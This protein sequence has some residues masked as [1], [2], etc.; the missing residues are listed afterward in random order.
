M[1][2]N[3]PVWIHTIYSVIVM[4]YT[5][6]NMLYIRESYMYCVAL[7]AGRDIPASFWW[8]RTSECSHLQGRQG[9]LSQPL[10]AYERQ[11]IY[12]AGVDRMQRT[13]SMAA[14]ESA[15]FL[16]WP[17]LYLCPW[18]RLQSGGE[19]R[20]DRVQVGRTNTLIAT[21]LVPHIPLSLRWVDGLR[22]DKVLLMVMF[23]RGMFGT[24]K[25][26]GILKNAF[27]L[28]KK[29][30]ANTNILYWGQ[31]LV[32]L[33]EGG[34][35]H[36]MDPISLETIG[37]STLGGVLGR[38]ETLTAHPRYDPVKARQIFFSADVGPITT[39]V[40]LTLDWQTIAGAPF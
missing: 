29:N 9:D 19:K 33:W 26:G 28:R 1:Y 36:S 6:S 15:A 10:R 25:S 4:I 22:S 31:K 18:K 14:Y 32:A 12:I 2:F 37:E 40:R 35:P 13:E 16:T 17:L 39:K 21:S 23:I 27:D 24:V 30:V 7:Y 20:Q 11:V 38:G 8:R 34:L 5:G 3:I